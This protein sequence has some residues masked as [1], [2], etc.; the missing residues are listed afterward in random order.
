MFL[1]WTLVS[2]TEK[3]GEFEEREREEYKEFCWKEEKKSTGEG[4]YII[5]GEKGIFV[6]ILMYPITLLH[7]IFIAKQ[8]LQNLLPKDW[9]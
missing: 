4:E 6:C 7:H 3:K 8:V 1:W 2:T 9:L 5:E